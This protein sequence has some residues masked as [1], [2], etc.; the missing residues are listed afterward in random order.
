MVNLLHLKSQYEFVSDFFKELKHN[1]LLTFKII[2]GKVHDLS[3]LSPQCT[4][5]NKY[6][7][8]RPQRNFCV[9]LFSAAVFCKVWCLIFHIK[10]KFLFWENVILVVYRFI[11]IGKKTHCNILKLIEEF[12]NEDLFFKRNFWKN[13]WMSLSPLILLSLTL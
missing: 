5:I 4:D 7:G 10:N 12:K 2:R 6:A 9:G 1:S 3:S 8:V 13:L 11:W